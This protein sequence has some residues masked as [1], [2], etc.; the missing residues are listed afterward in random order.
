VTCGVKTIN[1]SAIL[2]TNL[3]EGH[4][5]FAWAGRPGKKNCLRIVCVVS[6][7]IVYLLIAKTQINR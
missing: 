3:P 2:S 6:G 4:D 5:A 7:L 1:R